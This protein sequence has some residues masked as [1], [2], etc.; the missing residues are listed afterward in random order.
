MLKHYEGV[1]SLQNLSE[2][3]SLLLKEL[4]TQYPSMAQNARIAIL[5]QKSLNSFSGGV[6]DL[7]LTWLLSRLLKANMQ[8]DDYVL[9]SYKRHV[10]DAY[11]RERMIEVVQGEEKLLSVANWNPESS[12]IDKIAVPTDLIFQNLIAPHKGKVVYVIFWGTWCGPCIDEIPHTNA[13]FASLKDEPVVFLYLG[14]SSPTD[15]W[16][17]VIAKLNIAGSHYNLNEEEYRY[18]K[19]KFKINGVPRHLLIDKNGNIVQSHAPGASDEG[20]KVQIENLF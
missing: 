18:L 15:T 20:L 13:L 8:P 11:L 2:P 5:F 19:N 3:D 17:K 9:D 16:K 14:V 1:G 6:K 4:F 7:L 12:M 10:K